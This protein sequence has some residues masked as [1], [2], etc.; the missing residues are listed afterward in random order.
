M[1]P[2]RSRQSGY[3]WRAE[4]PL[5]DSD[6]DFNHL[7]SSLIAFPAT[8]PVNVDR[9]FVLFRRNQGYFGD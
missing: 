8:T 5:T 3:E 1:G 6:L 2:S 7:Y 4:G 9:F